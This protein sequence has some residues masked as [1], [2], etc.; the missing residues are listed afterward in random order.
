[1][2]AECLV[3]SLELRKLPVE[4]NPPTV[5]EG[6]TSCDWKQVFLALLPLFKS[7]SYLKEGRQCLLPAH[8]LL[9]HPLAPGLG[10]QQKGILE[11]EN[12]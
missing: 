11:G 3:E 1:M 5:P 6:P 7:L 4:A 10:D 9:H 12:N 8:P 2:Q